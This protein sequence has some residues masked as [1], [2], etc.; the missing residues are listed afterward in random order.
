MLL[1]MQGRIYENT[2]P[3]SE[4][5]NIHEVECPPI[6]FKGSEEVAK[7]PGLVVAVC[8]YQGNVGEEGVAFAC[9]AA[10]QSSGKHSIPS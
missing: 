9:C 8:Y 7:G 3:L 10:A 6:V 4:Q 1:L 2:N 5:E